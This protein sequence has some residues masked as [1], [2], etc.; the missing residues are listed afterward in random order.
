MSPWAIF[1][2]FTN[3]LWA[4]AI[5]KMNSCSYLHICYAIYKSSVET[6]GHRTNCFKYCPFSAVDSGVNWKRL[7]S[8]AQISSR[9][10]LSKK[11]IYLKFLVRLRSLVFRQAAWR[12]SASCEQAN[13]WVA[14]MINWPSDRWVVVNWNCS[15]SVWAIFRHLSEI[16]H[17]RIPYCV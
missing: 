15:G 16:Q 3:Q 2:Y 13:V 14:E 1:W 11:A 10:R 9:G 4:W 8:Y 7:D 6:I 5:K 12:G 17:M